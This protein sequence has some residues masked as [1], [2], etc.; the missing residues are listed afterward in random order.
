IPLLRA[1]QLHEILL[2]FKRLAPLN[3]APQAIVPSQC[4]HVRRQSREEAIAYHQ[5]GRSRGMPGL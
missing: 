4:H 5:Y 1:L 3:G 2:L